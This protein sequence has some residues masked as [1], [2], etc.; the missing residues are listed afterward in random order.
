MID[1]SHIRRSE[2]QKDEN[3]KLINY[4]NKKLVVREHKITF[5]KAIVLF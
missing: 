3:K 1:Y 2:L 4:N 5:Q